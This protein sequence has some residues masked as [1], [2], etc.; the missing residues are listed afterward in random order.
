MPTKNSLTEMTLLDAIEHKALFA[1]WFKKRFF[2][3]DQTW[4][5]WLSF[6]RVL[7]GHDLT[8]ADVELFKECTGRTDRPGGG[9]SEA[10]LICGRRAGK[11]FIISLIAV[12]LACFFD[13]GQYLQLGERGTIAIMAKDR[14]QCGTIFNY[15]TKLLRGVRVL[16]PLIQRETNEL[17]ELTNGVNIEITTASFR[18]IRSRSIIAALCDELAFWSDEGSNPDV[19]VLRAIRPGMGLIPGAM[20]LCAS[21]P[22]ARRGALWDAYSQDFGKDGSDVLVWKAPTRTMNPTFPQRTIDRAYQKDPSDAAAEY[23]AEFRTDVETFIAREV[24]EHCIIP[25]RYEL[26]PQEGV[27]YHAFTDPSGGSSD[28]MTLAIAHVENG[29]SVLDLVREAKPPFSPDDVAK[30]FMETMKAYGITK[31]VGDNYAGLW[32]KER[33]SVHGGYYEK[34]ERTKSEI[35]LAL[36][37][38]LNSGLVQLLDNDIVKSQLLNLERHTARGGKDQILHAR[39]QHDDVINAV[40]GAI[41]LTAVH[42][43]KVTWILSTLGDAPS[44]LSTMRSQMSSV[45][46]FLRDGIAGQERNEMQ[47]ERQMIYETGLQDRD[48]D[49]PNILDEDYYRMKDV[50]NGVKIEGQPLDWK[51]IRQIVEDE[52]RGKGPDWAE[53]TRKIQEQRGSA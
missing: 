52:K 44:F 31:V 26:P 9:F 12:Y 14:T 20:L 19:E 23:G 13:W 41:V 42:P 40:A 53:I 11:S 46:N 32:P 50:R 30:E 16:E 49:E 22:Y 47:P 18:T 45:A 33:F 29:V 51:T 37:P 1:P 35:Y 25:G 43:N 10:W 38:I 24:V 48:P 4:D 7:F 28:S 15:I 2:Q 17:I 36:L 39:G 5:R 8:E 3:Q 21:S 34:S 6:L 27:K